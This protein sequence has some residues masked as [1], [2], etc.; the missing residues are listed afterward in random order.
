MSSTPHEGRGGNDC[1]AK[2]KVPP[3]VCGDVKG[4]VWDSEDEERWE[5]RSGEHFFMYSIRA[6]H[7]TWHMKTSDRPRNSVARKRP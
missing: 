6:A 2:D 4:S 5:W 7:G 1:C 3:I